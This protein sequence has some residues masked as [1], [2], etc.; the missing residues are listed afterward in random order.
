MLNII[1]GR[2]KKDG[3][4][5]YLLCHFSLKNTAFETVTEAALI[6]LL[7]RNMKI[8]NAVLN[9]KGQ[10]KG[11]GASLTR[12]DGKPR[13][14]VVLS[15]LVD[16]ANNTIGFRVA[17]P[18]GECFKARAA[19]ILDY[20]RLVAKKGGV[21]FQNAIFVDDGTESSFIKSYPD[22]PFVTEVFKQERNKHAI[23]ESKPVP[24]PTKED[25]AELEKQLK[26]DLDKSAKEIASKYTREQ[27]VQLALGLKSGV[28]IWNYADPDISW[29]KMKVLRLAMEA[30]YDVSPLCSRKYIIPVDINTL[31]YVEMCLRQGIDV[32]NLLNPEYT[33]QQLQEIYTGII[34]YVDINQYSDPKIPA[35]EMAKI[36]DTLEVST[37]RKVI[38]GGG[39]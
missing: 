2:E 24:A 39:V 17:T 16:E 27:K 7:R 5:Y 15:R 31:M 29:Q 38:G 18:L 23:E 32:R 19:K 11:S 20:C 33:M 21:P 37:W 13:P 12:F 28:N 10:L 9:D 25:K 26:D 8:E 34:H 36:R 4:L 14:Y 30:G 35:S 1:V 22:H 3:V 6:E